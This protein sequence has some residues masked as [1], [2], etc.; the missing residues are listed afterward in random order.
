MAGPTIVVETG[1]N[2][3]GANSY[4]SQ[5]DA[6]TYFTNVGDTVFTAASPDQ[7]AAALVRACYGLGYWLN[8]RWLGRRANQVQALDWP[9]CGVYDSDNY[10]IANNV[11][12]QKLQFAQ[13]EVAKI[14]LTTPFIQQSVSKDDCVEMVEVGPIR[15]QYKPTAPSI[16]YWPQIIAMLR[17]FAAIGIMPIQV[18]IGLSEREMRE[19]HRDDHGFGMNPFDFPDYFH[20]IKEPIYN[21]GLPVGWDASWL[22]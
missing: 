14:E 5:A 4:I 19:M 20:L 2:V 12:P 6:L 8:G 15:T 7:Q 3:P 21:P 1:A 16:T 22:I 10:L 9:R 17:D 11:V 13:C 18:T